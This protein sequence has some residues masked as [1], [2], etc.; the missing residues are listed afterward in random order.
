LEFILVIAQFN[1]IASVSRLIWSFPVDKGLPFPKYF[2]YISVHI[3]SSTFFVQELIMICGEQVSPKLQV[4][5][6]ALI[7]IGA[8]CVLLA[9]IPIGS[10]VGFNAFMSLP[11]V[12]YYISYFIPILFIMI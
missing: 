11:V 10:T 4:R 5:I 2:A 9:I 7:L 3:W 8:V 12:S 1:T 6:N